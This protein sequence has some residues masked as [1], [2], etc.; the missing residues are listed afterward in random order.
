[1]RPSTRTGDF[2]G[3]RRPLLRQLP[4]IC[5]HPPPDHLCFYQALQATSGICTNG[6]ECVRCAHH[7]PM[8]S[9]QVT[10]TLT[11]NG[12]P[13]GL[14][15]GIPRPVP[16]NE[17]R[18]RSA[19]QVPE[20]EFFID[21]LLVRVHRCFWCTG[22]APWEFESPFPGSLISTFLGPG[23]A[24]LCSDTWEIFQ[25]VISGRDTGLDVIVSYMLDASDS[26]DVQ[27]V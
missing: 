10:L 26:W 15:H 23:P 4:E 24:P 1:M 9:I 2:P 7:R 17:E 22:L 8:C 25:R 18:K 27:F 20:R 3:G 16:A 12:K 13:E 14:V 21:S 19:D 5:Y 6:Y 11:Y